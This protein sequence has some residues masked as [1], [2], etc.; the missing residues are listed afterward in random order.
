MDVLPG[1]TTKFG[2]KNVVVA[3]IEGPDYYFTG[4]SDITPE[5]LGLGLGAFDSVAF[6]VSQSGTY[7]AYARFESA[8]DGEAAQTVKMVVCTLNGGAEVAYGIDL[9]AEVFRMFAVMV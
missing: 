2:N 1:Y 7:I 6:S 9:G 3:D 4:G 5:S 8:Y